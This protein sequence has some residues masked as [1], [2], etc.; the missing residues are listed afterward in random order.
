M[1]ALIRPVMT[2][3]LGRCVARI[4]WMPRRARLL[5]QARD[6]LLDLL[7]DDHHQVGEL[8][9]DDDDERQP[10][11]RLGLLGRQAERVG[12]RLAAL[13]RLGDL[14]VVA[15]DRLRT[16]SLLISL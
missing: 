13:G 5:R 3:T 4:R 11:E 15:G 7:A 12:Q 1:L 9:D 8:V 10:L 14:L 2:S 16:P 6:Q